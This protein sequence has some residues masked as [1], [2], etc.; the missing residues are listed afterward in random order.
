MSSSLDSVE[1]GYD[2]FYAE[3]LGI[4]YIAGL[5]ELSRAQVINPSEFSAQN[6]RHLCLAALHGHIIYPID[7]CAI[8]KRVSDDSP[9]TKTIVKRMEHFRRMVSD[10]NGRQQRIAPYAGGAITIVID[11]DDPFT[12][13]QF[14]IVGLEGSAI[15]KA[16]L[17]YELDRKYLKLG[18]SG[19]LNH[20]AQEYGFPNLEAL[21]VFVDRLDIEAQ[22]MGYESYATICT[23]TRFIDYLGRNYI[24]QASMKSALEALH[25]KRDL[26]QQQ[27]AFTIECYVACRVFGSHEPYFVD[28]DAEGVLIE[29]RE[30]GFVGTGIV[31][32]RFLS[33]RNDQFHGEW[34]A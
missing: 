11:D 32:S 9:Y 16:A 24:G 31:S 13:E 8:K 34:F 4:P 33:D 12:S 20:F 21:K 18:R 1:F 19:R 5:V 7:E 29:L 2:D 30:G 3:Y 25:Q 22:V 28:I 15:A 10:F 23:S 26:L 27:S 17:Q 6:P 14:E